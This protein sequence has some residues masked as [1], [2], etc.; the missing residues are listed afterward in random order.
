MEFSRQEYWSGVSFLSPGDLPN[1]GIKPGSTVLQAD[2]L[3]SEPLG[4]PLCLLRY[5]YSRYFIIFDV[6][7]KWDYFL[8]FSFWSFIIIISECK[9]FLCILQLYWIHWYIENA[10]DVTRKLAELKN[11]VLLRGSIRYFGF[12]RWLSGK[13]S[14][15]NAED[16]ESIPGFRRSPGEGNSNPLQYSCLGNPMNRGAWWTTVHRIAESDSTEWTH[17]RYFLSFCINKK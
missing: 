16:T 1:T 11:A 13:E 9:I 15:C 4:K 2:S 12:L 6:I 5:I 7:V 14:A 17:I 3:P 8:N 10:K